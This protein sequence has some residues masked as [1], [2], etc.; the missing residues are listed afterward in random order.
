[1]KKKDIF[2]NAGIV[3]LA[4]VIVIVVIFKFVINRQPVDSF[5]IN[6]PGD[7][8]VF[9]LSGSEIQ[10]QQIISKNGDTYCLIFKINDCPS[11]IYDGVEILIKLKAGGKHCIGIVTHDLLDEV[12]GWTINFDF[13]PFFMLQTIDFFEH[14]KSPITPV[15]VKFK[16]QDIASYRYF[17]PH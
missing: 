1:M 15:L 17:T 6:E 13:R 3:I 10:F 2:L 14:I 16:N 7:I 12:N 11:C 4:V 8:K 5:A 9:D